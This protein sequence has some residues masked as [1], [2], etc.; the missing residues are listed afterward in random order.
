MK[1]LSEFFKRLNWKQH[2]AFWTIYPICYMICYKLTMVFPKVFSQSCLGMLDNGPLIYLGLLAADPEG[3]VMKWFKKLDFDNAWMG[4]VKNPL[5]LIV[6][7]NALLNTGT[8]GIGAAGDPTSSVVGVT[9]GCLIVMVIFPITW[10]LRTR[11]VR[12]KQTNQ[13]VA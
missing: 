4:W 1:R 12:S 6:C 9:F 11:R 10:R 7:V 5:F 8:D 3:P 13:W 2:L